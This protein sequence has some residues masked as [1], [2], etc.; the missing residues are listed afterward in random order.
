MA[1]TEAPSDERR[2]RP[3]VSAELVLYL[4]AGVVYVVIG[5]LV[6]AFLFSWIVAAAY[7]ISFVVVSTWLMRRLR[8]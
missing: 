6:P 8:R 5:V 7:L 1:P 2:R 3:V 4:V